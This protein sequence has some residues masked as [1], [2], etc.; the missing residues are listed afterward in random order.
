MIPL[1]G[2]ISDLIATFTT[3]RLAAEQLRSAHFPE[4]HRL[5][6]DAQVMASLSADGEPLSEEKPR[7]SLQHSDKHGFGLWLFQ[8]KGN[9]EICSQSK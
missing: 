5:H 4:I 7:Q 9:G 1:N 2:A 8:S 6:S 3:A